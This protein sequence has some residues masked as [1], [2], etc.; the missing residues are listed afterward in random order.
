[1]DAGFERA[2][3]SFDR[4]DR[5]LRDLR[6][7]LGQEISGLRTTMMRFGSG[8]I[9]GLVGVIATVVINSPV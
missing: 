7:D 2:D 5:D 3:R 9:V 8:I 4:V 6:L 1:M